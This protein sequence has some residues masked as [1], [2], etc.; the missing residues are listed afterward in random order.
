MDPAKR[1]MHAG[2]INDVGKAV[3]AAFGA[4]ERLRD[5]SVLAVCGGTYSWNDYVSTLRALGHD[6]TVERIAA[7]A[8]DRL[9]PIA[10]EMRQTFE[11]FEQCTYFGPQAEAHIAAAR[12]LVPSGFTSLSNW[13][14][15]HLKALPA[16]AP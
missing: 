4:R 16:G 11:Y 10:P 7:Q 2:D 12:A 9:Y 5:G 13:A 15:V 14:A 3:A 6:V 1:V 8:Y